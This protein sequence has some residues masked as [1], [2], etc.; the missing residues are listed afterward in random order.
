MLK[1][2]LKKSL[3]M[4]AQK[5]VRSTVGKVYTAL[6][7]TNIYIYI[8]IINRMPIEILMLKVLLQNSHGDDI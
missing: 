1:S 6:E 4:K 3:L 8:Y 2:L 7:K 5:E